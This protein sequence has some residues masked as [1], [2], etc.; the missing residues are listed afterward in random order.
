MCVCTNRSLRLRRSLHFFLSFFECSLNNNDYSTFS[1]AD[2]ANN[3][4]SVRERENPRIPMQQ[5]Y[6]YWKILQ[7]GYNNTIFLCYM[8]DMAFYCT[9]H[10]SWAETC[11]LLNNTALHC[12]C[13]PDGPIDLTGPRLAVIWFKEQRSKNE[14]K[15]M[16]DLFG[17]Q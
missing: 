11:C 12:V 9:T 17:R 8:F 13:S 10:H 5:Y 2:E 3:A 16:I 14:N 6:Y 4:K 1:F 7:I 15:I